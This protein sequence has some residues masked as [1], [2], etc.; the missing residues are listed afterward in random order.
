M[1][2]IICHTLSASEVP[3]FALVIGNGAYTNLSRLANPVNDANDIA[4]V[5]TQM[6]FT[7][8]RVLNG[9][10]EQMESAVFR[11]RNRLSASD[12]AFG[13]FFYAGHG[14]QSGGE[15]FLI[16][17]DANIPTET[18]LRTRS[19]SVQ[20]ILSEL[21][22]ANNNLNIVV[23]DA[24][25][26]NPFGWSRAGNRGLSFIS[27]QPADSIIVFATSAGDVAD[28]GRGRNGLFTEHFLS[29]LSTPGLEVQE[30]FRRTGADVSR[31]SGNRQ[32][33]DVYSQFFGK[34]YFSPTT[35]GTIIAATPNPMPPP[36]TIRQQRTRAE[37]QNVDTA[38]DPDRFI[39]GINVNPASALTP[40]RGGGPS[41]NIELGKS[42]FLSEV[43]FII[44][45]HG[46]FGGLVK[47]NYFWHSRI[48]GAYL[49]GGLGGI[50]ATCH[51][52]CNLFTLGINTGYKFV[53]RS[54]LYFRTGAFVGYNFLGW[55][56]AY[57]K[58][59]LSIGWTMR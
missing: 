58:P 44:P 24:C 52:D 13:F 1:V 48:G 25:R 34:A 30:V 42:N 51:V 50:N 55:F 32:I 49:G 3:K 14:V 54:G 35:D 38:I 56:S 46:G 53:T 28:D 29:N 20:V 23:L 10:L 39:F 18:F 2:V 6:G 59:D 7:V 5:L 41:L 15:N 11:L 4:D 43:N 31:A 16:P 17:V 45:S 21:N 57:F 36:I 27:R 19:V 22:N 8:D 40:N 33:P 12:Y 37:R 26:D 47:F 9:C